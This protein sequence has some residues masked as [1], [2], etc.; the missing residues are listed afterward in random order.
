MG[1]LAPIGRDAL[2]QPLAI[3]GSPGTGA[4]FELAE[5]EGCE[6]IAARSIS[7]AFT[8]T[9]VTGSDAVTLLVLLVSSCM[10]PSPRYTG[11]RLRCTRPAKLSY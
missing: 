7:D 4:S 5:R 10:H 9:S 6:Y 8:C 2:A 11:D 3:M 1:L